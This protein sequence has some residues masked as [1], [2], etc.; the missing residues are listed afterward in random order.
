MMRY[1]TTHPTKRIITAI[2]TLLLT[3]PLTSHATTSTNTDGFDWEPVIKAIAHIESRGNASARNGSYVGLLQISPVLVTECNNIL[4][5]Q[6]S[7]KRYTLADRTN[8]QKSKEMFVLIQ[9]RHNPTN[10]IERAIRLWKGGIAYSIKKTQS[11][12]NRVMQRL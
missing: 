1:T 9:K 3:L 2:I 12:L 6:G 11:Y 4:K 5:S 7:S 8:V 10:N